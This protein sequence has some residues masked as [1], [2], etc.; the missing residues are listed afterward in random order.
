MRSLFGVMA[1]AVCMSAQSNV[2]LAEVVHSGDAAAALE[3]LKRGTSG[4]SAEP[5]GTTAL[6][7]AVQQDDARGRHARRPGGVHGVT[8]SVPVIP[9]CECGVPSGP[10]IVHQ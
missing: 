1:L 6:H 10:R 9:I 7:W 2:R 4:H 5:D 8:V 3:M